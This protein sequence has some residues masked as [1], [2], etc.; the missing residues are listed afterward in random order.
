MS[1][2]VP[3]DNDFLSDLEKEFGLLH[4]RDSNDEW[5]DLDLDL[6][7]FCLVA[8]F[9]FG[10]RASFWVHKRKDSWA[11]HIEYL[12]H[13][14]RIHCKYCMSNESFDKLVDHLRPA[15]EVD[16]VKAHDRCNH[17][18]YP[19]IVVAIGIRYLCGGS[20]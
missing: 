9:L 4:P 6:E 7:G 17:E 18:I 20:Y 16:I 14:D 19:E 5:D 12:E 15:I 13:T 2:F 11:E 10:E 1:D 8:A 3:F